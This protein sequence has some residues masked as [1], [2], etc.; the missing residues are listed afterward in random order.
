MPAPRSIWEVQDSSTF[1]INAN[2]GE[3]DAKCGAVHGTSGSPLL[4][5]TETKD[6]TPYA[7]GLIVGCR[8]QSG[9]ECKPLSAAGY[10]MSDICDFRRR[11]EWEAIA[12]LQE[13]GRIN[14]AASPD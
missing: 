2:L 5:A 11:Q 9:R 7:I 8:L 10:K 14:S 3:L 4:D 1:A 12:R 13:T 6:D